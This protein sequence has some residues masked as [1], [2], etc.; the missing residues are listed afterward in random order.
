MFP[1]LNSCIGEG[2][3]AWSNRIYDKMR[4]V[5]R[6]KKLSTIGMKR[7]ISNDGI[8]ADPKSSMPQKFRNRGEIN[9][10]PDAPEGEDSISLKA[11]REWLQKEFKNDSSVWNKQLIKE[12]ME[13]TFSDRRALI[14]C[15]NK[16]LSSLK[17]FY[18]FLFTCRGIIEEFS[19]LM[20]IDIDKTILSELNEIASHILKISEEKKKKRSS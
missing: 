6:K 12:K 11:H 13:L 14:N 4:E 18:P 20:A 2:W 16:S 17:E 9:W 7:K 8:D 10:A 5:R 19:L 3:H 1:K 15:N